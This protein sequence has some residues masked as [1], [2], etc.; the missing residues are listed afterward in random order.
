MRERARNLPSQSCRSPRPPPPYNARRETNQV[1][2]LEASH[3]HPK[4]ELPQ[5]QEP[6]DLPSG[7]RLRVL[8]EFVRQAAVRKIEVTLE[9]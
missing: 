1:E 3:T 8:T 9:T 5:C 6:I 7:R 4:L 2:H